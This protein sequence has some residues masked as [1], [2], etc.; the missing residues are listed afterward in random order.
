MNEKEQSESYYADLA[1]HRSKGDANEANAEGTI[2]PQREPVERT[3][4]YADSLLGEDDP[5][6]K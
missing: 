5:P 2:F 4:R 3:G 6:D 1:E